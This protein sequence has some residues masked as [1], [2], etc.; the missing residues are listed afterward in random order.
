MLRAAVGAVAIALVAAACV[1]PPPDDAPPPPPATVYD[2]ACAGTL[3]ASTPGT[4]E[5]DLV[6]ELSGIA[7]SR[8]N[9]GVWWV[10]NDSGNPVEV[11]AVGADGSDL[12]TFTLSDAANVD[13]EDV[14][15]GPGPVAGTHYLY[16]ADIGNSIERKRDGVVVYRVAEP[17]VSAGS[18]AV[19]GV[20]R[21]SLTYP[22]GETPDAESFLV[23]PVNG[24]LL[25]VTKELFT[26]RVFFAPANLPANS[27]TELT[28]VGTV[29]VPGFLAAFT[30]ADVTADGAFV[31]TRTDAYAGNGSV[32]IY[33]RPAGQSLAAAFAQPPCY[34]A[35]ASETQ[36]EAIGFTSDGRGYVTASEGTSPELHQFHAP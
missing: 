3:V 35:T 15:V 9:P 23:D 1:P 4:V 5:N 10:H 13:W 11:Y 17:D 33:R 18:A 31:A 21:L 29:G 25:I 14:A 19:G 2:A 32:V 7:A 16:L 12:G 6:Y 22:G 36:G 34:G 24:D 28:Q 30:A 27:T 20:A 26:S 8:R